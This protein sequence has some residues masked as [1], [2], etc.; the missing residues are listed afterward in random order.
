MRLRTISHL[1]I[2]T[3]NSPVFSLYM[4]SFFS[5]GYVD[6]LPENFDNTMELEKV[7]DTKN[8][9]HSFDESEI[10]YD[11]ILKQRQGLL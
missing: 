5:G 6:Y 4:N 2:Y 9:F 3:N 7:E 1:L 8:C 10:D 11:A